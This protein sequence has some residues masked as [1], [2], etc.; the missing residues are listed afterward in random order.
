MHVLKLI[1]WIKRN[2]R[3]DFN[4]NPA[5]VEHVYLFDEHVI[6]CQDDAY[7]DFTKG[8]RR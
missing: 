8:S 1:V 2:V 3:G 4:E 7:H 6:L 5:K